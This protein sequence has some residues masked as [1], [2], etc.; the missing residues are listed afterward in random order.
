MKDYEV[1]LI[2]STGKTARVYINSDSIKEAIK[3]GISEAIATEQVEQNAFQ[4][5]I[6]RGDIGED[7]ILALQH[8]GLTG[9]HLPPPHDDIGIGGAKFRRASFLS[10]PT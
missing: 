9:Y 7:A 8:R 3:S 10:R 6:A 2:D 4:N 5:A 1:N